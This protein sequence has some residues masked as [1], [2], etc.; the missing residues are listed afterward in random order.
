MREAESVTVGCPPK[1]VEILPL[2]ARLC[3]GFGIVAVLHNGKVMWHGDDD[4]VTLNDFEL[5]AQ[6]I[7]GAWSVRFEGPLQGSVYERRDAGLWELVETNRG[8]A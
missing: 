2:S 8:F 3:V 4:R 1:A 6:E 5:R 7:G